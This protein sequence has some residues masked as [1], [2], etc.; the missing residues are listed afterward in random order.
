M[1]EDVKP[2]EAS[3]SDWVMQHPRAIYF[4]NQ[5][6]HAVRSRLEAALTTLQM[7]GIQYTV[8]SVIGSRE[9]L[10][11]AELSRRFFVTPQTMNEL[12]G[13]LQRRNLITRKEDP[14]NRRI[15]RMSLTTEGKR[16]IKACDAAADTVERDIFSFLPQESYQ[17]LRDLCRLVARNLRERDEPTK[18]E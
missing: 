13:G 9:G 17:Q 5:A 18:A 16:M 8:L 12:I 3:T 10:S 15:L 14:A 6:N 1:A 2:E 4:L 11:S 7:T